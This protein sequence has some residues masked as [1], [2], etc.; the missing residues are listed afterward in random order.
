MVSDGSRTR[1]S[2]VTE[3][4]ANAAT[5]R[6]HWPKWE[7]NPQAPDSESGRYSNSRTRPMKKQIASPGVAPEGRGLSDPVEPRSLARIQWPRGDSNSHLSGLST[8]RLPVAPLGQSVVG[9]S[10]LRLTFTAEG[11]GFE[12]SSLI[13]SRVSCAVRPT[14]SGYLPNQIKL[15]V[16]P[17]G[18]EP[19]LS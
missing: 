10:L 12:P 3:P 5:Q 9:E 13:E 16:T 19:S 14:V 2:A 11:K 7:S 6:T 8:A 4:R 17:D 18:L 15:T 1:T